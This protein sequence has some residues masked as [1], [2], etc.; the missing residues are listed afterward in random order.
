MGVTSG[1]LYTVYI[2]TM[3]LVDRDALPHHCNQLWS[4]DYAYTVYQLSET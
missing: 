1:K 4:C 2:F 3:Y